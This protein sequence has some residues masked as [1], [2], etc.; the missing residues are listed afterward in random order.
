M[1]SSIGQLEFKILFDILR[2]KE[3]LILKLGQLVEY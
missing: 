1:T 3:S 2:R